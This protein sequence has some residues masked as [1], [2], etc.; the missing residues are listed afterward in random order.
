MK[1]RSLSHP[2]YSLL[3]VLLA[4]ALSVVVFSAL[5]SATRLHLVSL[6]KQKVA[7]ERKQI[8]R[9]VLAMIGNDLRAGIQYK[10]ADY[11]GLENLVQ[12]Q[13]MMVTGALPASDEVGDAVGDPVVADST[14]EEESEII[15]E[16]E[17]SFR[18]TL[19]GSESVVMIDI[20]RLPRLDQYNPLVAN[21]ATLAQSP[22]D[23][24]SLAYF[25]SESD[26]GIEQEIEFDVAAP[27]GLYRRE[28]DRA[29]AAYMGDFQMLDSPDE[30]TQLVAP[31]V[32]QI[33]FR[34]FDGTDW[35]TE[36]DS[37]E[38]GGFPTAIE[39]SIVIDPSR[40]SFN[41][42]TYSYAGF[43]QTTMEIYRSVVHL[44]AAEVIVEE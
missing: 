25:F 24:K 1:T 42:T 21:S 15:V 40:S 8:A 38:M 31:E 7:I 23:V 36:W 13:Q 10:A 37:A 29:V 6:T 34:Y 2:G 32:A 43:D 41:N 12:T 33:S 16:E 11:S 18:P 26:S 30:Y 4:L 9:S 17:V 27:G 39:T 20:S 19:I 3:E 28:I 22:S 44:P 5:A 14:A 35:Q